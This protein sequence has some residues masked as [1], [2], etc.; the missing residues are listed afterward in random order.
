MR[1]LSALMAVVALAG[2]ASAQFYNPPSRDVAPGTGRI[3]SAAPSSIRIDQRLNA[4]ISPD[5]QFVDEDAQPVTTGDLINERP[6]MLILLFYKCTGI[7]A[8]EMES[9]KKVVRGMKKDDAGEL[10][11]LVVVSID[12]TETPEMAKQKKA[13]LMESYKRPGTEGGIHFLTGDAKNIDGLAD[14]VGFRFYRDPENGNITHPAGM[15][16]VSPQRRLIRY[17]VSDTFEAKPTLLALKDARDERVGLKDDRPFFLACVN[18]DPLTGR[19]SLNVLNVVRVA[20]VATVLALA[21]WIISMN[22]SSK[23]EEMDVTTEEGEA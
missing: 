21:F 19:R 20:G 15:M 16:I 12:P 1:F 8:T 10:Y 18:V 4:V 17:F 7:C 11:D 3:P 2:V 9:L 13:E 23:K 22:R 14:E 6:V 5:W